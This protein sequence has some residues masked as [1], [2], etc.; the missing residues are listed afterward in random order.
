VAA[1]VEAI[2]FAH[3]VYIS[4][5]AVY[6]DDAIRFAKL[7]AQSNDIVWTDAPDA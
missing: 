1:V 6:E 4:S 2:K 7:P 5:D 3:V